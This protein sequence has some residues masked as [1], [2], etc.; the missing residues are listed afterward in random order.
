M[1]GYPSFLEAA[2]V[3]N[4]KQATFDDTWDSEAFEK[5]ASEL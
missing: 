2:S 5:K 1:N 4:N 3:M